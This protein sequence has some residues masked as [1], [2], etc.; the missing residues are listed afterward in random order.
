MAWL[1]PPSPHRE[2]SG[3]SN[4]SDPSSPVY[5]TAGW[6]CV[7]LCYPEVIVVS[8]TIELGEKSFIHS[9][10]Q[11]KGTQYLL[12]GETG[13]SQENEDGP[14]CKDRCRQFPP[15]GPVSPP[16]GPLPT[17][18]TQASLPASLSLR[19]HSGQWR[20]DRLDIP[21]NLCPGQPQ[22]IQSWSW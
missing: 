12:R 19:M 11:H 7:I 2:P 14:C 1:A 17:A 15:H 6:H 21:G 9:F 10:F 16:E 20:W 8:E 18:P 3:P 22:A 5:T 13:V 4:Q